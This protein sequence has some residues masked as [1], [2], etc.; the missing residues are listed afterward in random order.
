VI[1]VEHVAVRWE[2]PLLFLPAGVTFQLE[3]EIKNVVTVIA[4]THPSWTEHAAAPML[5]YQ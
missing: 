3:H 2:K 4:K 5:A 1:I